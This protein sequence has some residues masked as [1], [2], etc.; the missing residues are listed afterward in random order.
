MIIERLVKPLRKD[1]Q[2]GRFFLSTEAPGDENEEQETPAPKHNTKVIDIKPNKRIR[3]DFPDEE[4]ITPETEEIPVEE[5][6]EETE[7]VEDNGPVTDGEDFEPT[8]EEPVQDD[9]KSQDND[10]NIEEPVDGENEPAQE[11]PT[12]DGPVIDGEDFE[13]TDEEP[14]QDDETPADGGPVTDG[15]DFEPTD[16]EGTANTN[17]PQETNN[18]ENTKKGPGLEYDSTRKYLLFKNYGSLI[19]SIDNYIIKLEKRMAD[20]VRTNRISK[21]AIDKLREIRELAYDFMTMKFEISSYIQSLLFFQN[22]IA[23]VQLVFNLLSKIEVNN[24]K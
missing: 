19:N 20:D 14:V 23:M 8:D 5:P 15:E 24:K 17:Q 12:D 3:I 6:T 2:Y 4:E 16:D 18:E 9:V 1:N 11:E 21:N 13:P 7:P 22:L 10:D